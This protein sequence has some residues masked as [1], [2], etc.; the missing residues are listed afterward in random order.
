MT[1]TAATTD[2]IIAQHMQVA[3]VLDGAKALLARMYQTPCVN[4]HGYYPREIIA[5]DR[6]VSMLQDRLDAIECPVL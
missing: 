2:R 5:Q 1:N 6:R 3:T 4:G